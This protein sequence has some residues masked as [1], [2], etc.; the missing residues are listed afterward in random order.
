MNTDIASGI[1]VARQAEEILLAARC[2]DAAKSTATLIDVESAVERLALEMAMLRQVGTDLIFADDVERCAPFG[3]IVANVWT[4]LEHA[5]Q[6][7]AG[8]TQ[9]VV[10]N[11]RVSL[12]G[13]SVV[14]ELLGVEAGLGRR[15]CLNALCQLLPGAL[16]RVPL[17]CDCEY[18][19]GK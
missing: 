10:C 1:A 6:A 11:R 8:S 15:D 12:D 18:D 3:Q 17:R 14:V 13:D 16:M 5:L 7:L 4:M 9:G 2:L 19:A